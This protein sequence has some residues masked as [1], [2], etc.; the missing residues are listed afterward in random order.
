M[1]APG[2]P[3][4]FVSTHEDALD[5]THSCETEATTTVGSTWE[6]LEFDFSNESP[7]TAPLNLSY[8]FSRVSIY[9]NYGVTGS[10]AGTKTY[11]FDNV[12]F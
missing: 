7:G 11:Y 8:T 10:M 4:A 12:K 1:P 3:I 2:G 9:F 6:T 5:P